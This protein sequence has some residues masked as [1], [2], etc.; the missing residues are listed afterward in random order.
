MEMI[1]MNELEQSLDKHEENVD[2]ITGQGDAHSVG[3]DRDD[4]LAPAPVGKERIITSEL[5]QPLEKQEENID[6]ITGQA[7]AQSVGTG[8]GNGLA[9]AAIAGIVGAVLGTVAATLA[10]KVT[11]QRINRSVKSVGDAVKDVAKGVNH[12]AKGTVDRVKDIEDAKLS[13][14]QTFKLYEERLVADKRQVKTAEV[15][16]GKHVETQTAHI[17]VPLKKERVVVERILPTDAGTPVTLDEANFYEGEIVRIKVYEETPDVQKQ[18]FVREEVSV[19]KEVEQVSVELEDK[20][21]REELDLDFQD[22]NAIDQTK[23]L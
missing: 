4:R 8:M 23:T 7:D 12:T 3:T 13:D 10:G 1:I 18:A 15:S 19:R 16:I 6:S 5:E 14:N 9:R 2:S 20:I 21:R 22:A 17:S 11:A